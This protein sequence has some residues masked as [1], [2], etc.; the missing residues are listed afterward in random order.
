MPNTTTDHVRVIAGDPIE[1]WCMLVESGGFRE[2]SLLPASGQRPIEIPLFASAGRI[3]RTYQAT[4]SSR[5]KRNHTSGAF[6]LLPE[7]LVSYFVQ[8]DWPGT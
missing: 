1:I 8:Y 6:A 7:L 3:S 5:V 2:G 4:C